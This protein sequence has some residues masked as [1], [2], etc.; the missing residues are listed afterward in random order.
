MPLPA[1]LGWTQP[2]G[3]VPGYGP[4]DAEDSRTLASLLAHHPATQWCITLT[5]P[6]DPAPPDPAPPG[7]ARPQTVLIPRPRSRT[8]SPASPSPRWKP[9]TAPTHANHAVGGDGGSGLG[10]LLGTGSG[11]GRARP[12]VG[13][14]ARRRPAARAG[15]GAD[16][17]LPAALPVLLEPDAASRRRT[18]S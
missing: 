13:A 6:T 12:D 14:P 4:V 1:W 16:V 5:G 10:S 7:P 2:P 9:A 11:D 15:R 18:V 8:G 17:P 3:D